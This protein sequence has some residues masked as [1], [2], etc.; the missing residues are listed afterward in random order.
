MTKIKITKKEIEIEVDEENV[1]RVSSHKWRQKGDDFITDVYKDDN[2][3]S[4]VTLGR[5]ILASNEPGC[6][7]RKNKQKDYTVKNLEIQTYSSIAQRNKRAGRKK[8]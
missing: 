7:I 6:V 2:T 3:R 4:T 5:F 1:V 8:K